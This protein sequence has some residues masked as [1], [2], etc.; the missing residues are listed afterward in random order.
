MYKTFSAIALAV[1]TVLAPL[2][3]QS[4]TGTILCNMNVG[5]FGNWLPEQV[6]ILH[7]PGADSATVNDPIIQYFAKGPIKAKVTADSAKRLS[8]SWDVTVVSRTGNRAKMSYSLTIQKADLHASMTARPAG[9]DNK[10]SSG[11]NCKRQ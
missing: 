7:E 4:K 10:F 3:A 6:A 1:C 2:A 11:G 9:Y 5:K 8:L